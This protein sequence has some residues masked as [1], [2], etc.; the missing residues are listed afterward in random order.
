LGAGQAA[1]EFILF[2]VG[3]LVAG[4]RDFVWRLSGDYRP[5]STAFICLSIILFVWCDLVLDSFQDSAA[6]LSEVSEVSDCYSIFLDAR[7]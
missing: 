7:R 6:S 3:W 5:R 4:R 1:S 2:D